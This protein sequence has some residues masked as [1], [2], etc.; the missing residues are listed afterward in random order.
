MR[1]IINPGKIKYFLNKL[2]EKQDGMSGLENAIILIAFVTVASV[3]AYNVL[4]SGI[5]SSERAKATVYGGLDSA[6]NSIELSSSVVGLSTNQTKLESVYFF[7]A[8][9]VPTSTVDANTIIVNYWDDEIHAEGCTVTIEL[10]S[11]S[12]ERGS[13]DILEHDKQ[14]KVTVELPASSSITANE[15]FNLMVLPPS[16]NSVQ[17]SREMPAQITKVIHFK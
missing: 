1:N 4:S 11:D 10:A 8:L 6:S 3:L 12:P 5:F 14:F 16:G 13:T 17:I 2:I 9:A 7:I 15:R